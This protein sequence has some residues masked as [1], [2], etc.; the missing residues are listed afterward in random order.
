[1]TVWLVENLP[2]SP[3]L[4]G[5]L[6]SL[7]RAR[8]KSYNG[9]SCKARIMVTAE[10]RQKKYGPARTT[11]PVP[12]ITGQLPPVCRLPDMVVRCLA[13]SV[14]R[15][16]LAP[17]GSLLHPVR[18]DQVRSDKDSWGRMEAFKFWETA[19]DRKVETLLPQKTAYPIFVRSHQDVSYR[20]C[21]RSHS[22]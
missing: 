22:F 19:K 14:L 9:K 13:L 10:T 20:V 3:C 17:L 6:C 5:P 21:L 1:M 11:S 12:R 8:G 7:R 18:N 2:S 4:L 16:A 15:I